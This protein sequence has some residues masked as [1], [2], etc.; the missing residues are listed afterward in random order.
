MDITDPSGNKPRFEIK[1]VT[2]TISDIVYII[3]IISGTLLQCGLGVAIIT[4][5]ILFTLISRHC[6]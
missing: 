2:R 6:R 4:V 5:T 3:T 1:K